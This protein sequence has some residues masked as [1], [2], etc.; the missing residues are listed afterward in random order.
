M[1]S[2]EKKTYDDT[3]ISMI[4]IYLLL[5]NSS[6]DSRARRHNIYNASKK[7]VHG[8]FRMLPLESKYV[9][10]KLNLAI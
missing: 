4:K 3:R 1:T 2:Q 8:K 9:E 6:N 7:N 5:A 10:T